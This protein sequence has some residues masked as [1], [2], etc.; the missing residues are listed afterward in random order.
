MIA[1]GTLVARVFLVRKASSTKVADIVIMT[2]TS[3]LAI[4][5]PPWTLKA[6]VFMFSFHVPSKQLLPSFACSPLEHQSMLSRS[7]KFCG[8]LGSVQVIRYTDS[9]VGPYDE[10][11][12]VPGSFESDSTEGGKVTTKRNLRVSRIYVSQRLTCYNGRIS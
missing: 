6:T 1:N 5:P 2:E 11:L 10:M 3:A 7:S 12:L 4:A 9:P 8:G